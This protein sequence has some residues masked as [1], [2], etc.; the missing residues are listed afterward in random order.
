[1]SVKRFK[2]VS[3]GVFLNEVD[4]SRLPRPP[5]A[6]GPTIIGRLEKGPGLIPLTIQSMAQFVEVF[7][8]PQPGG[9]GGDIWRDGNKTA[10]TYAAYAAQAYLQNSG[11][12]NVVRLLGVEDSNAST[13]GAAGW[14]LGSTHAL[15]YGNNPA[16][17]AMAYGLY[18]FS[19]GGIDHRTSFLT[20]SGAAPNVH[21]NTAAG[22]VAANPITGTL[23]AV[24]YF[25]KG[26]IL[27][28]GSKQTDIGTTTNT[29]FWGRR[30]ATTG[31]YALLKAKDSDKM[32][33]TT[34][35]YDGKKE[36]SPNDT[37]IEGKR[38]VF[39]F[40]PDS[41]RYIRKVFNTNPTIVN[42][43]VTQ[44][45]GVKNYWLGETYDRYVKDVHGK[46]SGNKLH[47]GLL[48]ADSSLSAMIV[49]LHK[50]SGHAN[51]MARKSANKNS[52][53][54]WF[55]SQDLISGREKGQFDAAKDTEKLFRFHGIND[56]GWNAA[57][58]KI[59]I[60]DV[61][62]GNKTNPYGT[63]TVLIRKVNDSD[64]RMI[65][66]ER[67]T[68]CTLNPTDSD[69]V[70]LKIGD[71]YR[72]WDEADKRYRVYGDYR[73]Q[74][75]F[76]RIEVTQDVADGVTESTLLPFGFY[77]PPRI[78]TGQLAFSSVKTTGIRD[79]GSSQVLAFASGSKGDCFDVLFSVTGSDTH[80]YRPAGVHR[81]KAI[82]HPVGFGIACTA[83]LVY[84]TLSMR[85]TAS[86]GGMSDPKKACFGVSTSRTPDNPR[87]DQSYVDVVRRLPT[88]LYPATA[89]DIPAGSTTVERSFIFTLD[90]VIAVHKTGSLNKAGHHTVA[91]FGPANIG[92][93]VYVSGS[94]RQKVSYTARRG[95]YKDLLKSGFNSFTSP[96]WGGFDGLN[97]VEMEPFNNRAGGPLAG[98]T[99]A[100]SYAQASL[101]RAV[102]TVADP[103]VIEM[104]A[105]A[106]PG[107]T[108]PGATDRVIQVCEDRADALAVIDI[109]NGGYIPT[110]E[111]KND[112]KTRIQN[113]KVD[114]AVTKL[115]ARGINSSYACTFFPWVKILDQNKD[116]Q[117]WVPPSVVALGT[118]AFTEA[119]SELWFAPAGFTRGGLS[120]GAAGIPVLGVSQRLSTKERDTLYENSIN[121]IA[122]FP[123]EGIVVFGQKTLQVSRSAL[124]RINV[125]RLMIFVKKEVS[126]MA[127]TLLFDNN[128]QATWDRFRGRVEPFLDSVKSRF[129]LTEFKVILDETTTTPDL[130]DRNIMYAKIFLKPARAIEYIAIDFVIT[131]SGASFED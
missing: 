54:G 100:D 11:P 105:L 29:H 120:D 33:F 92:N 115:E 71:Q 15:G 39:N 106:I 117:L 123:A 107:V 49:P 80:A 127:A 3:P 51:P 25:E 124:D 116:R 112:F 119:N 91:D 20:G 45:D 70:G 61:R 109:E 82:D 122:K 46:D 16:T 101:K 1:M 58:I 42:G 76:I 36:S 9:E 94:R 34:M 77:G 86:E 98:L 31:S 65:I 129:G 55:I 62:A 126:R 84:P 12:V 93:A 89:D 64:G 72:E 30:G 110:T 40:D 8:D 14:N 47:Q 104:N 57:N 35:L 24:W 59:S 7:G 50:V 18:L 21:T 53:T 27:L 5:S 23:A 73:N 114:T 108:D 118:F 131:N 44:D 75:S 99:P 83:S 63:F 60:T 79:V 10:P 6:V 13:A 130:I 41:D 17:Q 2:F 43:D 95:G 4:N 78:K 125:R 68:G 69:Y 28:S 22:N 81:W 88:D 121:P 111:G 85:L 97:I 19:K 32:E 38:V 102:D 103:E 26:A 48:T 37:V 96:M 74:S 67:Y 90:D 56:G 66:L 128:V 87:F 113:S 52:V